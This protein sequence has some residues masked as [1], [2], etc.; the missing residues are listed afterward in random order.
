MDIPYMYVYRVAALLKTKRHEERVNGLR[1]QR[2]VCGHNYL[3]GQQFQEM[4][5]A[6][7]K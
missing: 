1:V 7:A 6:V 2:G 3:P 4:G 5:G